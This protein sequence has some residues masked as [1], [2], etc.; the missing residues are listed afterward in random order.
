[1][2]VIVGGTLR[3]PIQPSDPHHALYA[4]P[5]RLH[6]AGVTFAI[7]SSG[8]GSNWPRRRATSRMKRPLRWRFGLPEAEAACV[9]LPFTRRI[10]GIADQV[11]SI[12]VGKRAD[13]VITAGHILQPTTE[14]KGSFCAWI[15]LARESPHPALRPISPTS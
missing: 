15:T 6:E 2:P 4:N 12:E 11:G 5:A 14:V 13:L 9:P 1:M 10:L 7:R 3:L 8:K